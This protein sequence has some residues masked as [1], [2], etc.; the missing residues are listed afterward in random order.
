MAR[1]QGADLRGRARQA[2]RG[3]VGVRGRHAVVPGHRGAAAGLAPGCAPGRPAGR[4]APHRRA[5]AVGGPG[6]RVGH[7]TLPPAQT[8]KNSPVLLHVCTRSCTRIV[9][10]RP[11]LLWPAGAEVR[12][13]GGLSGRVSMK[14]G[15]LLCIVQQEVKIQK[16]LRVPCAVQ[17]CGAA[18]AGAAPRQRRAHLPY[19][20]RARSAPASRRG[21]AA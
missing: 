13:A 17:A 10:W 9:W 7:F 18:A 5:H 15:A 11:P 8:R 4:R 14:R 21:G 12:H 6:A 1:V 2:C 19:L 3:P 16:R 20:R